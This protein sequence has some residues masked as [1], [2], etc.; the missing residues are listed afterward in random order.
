MGPSPTQGGVVS[1]IQ[2]QV[3]SP[4]QGG[5]PSPTQGGV[6]SPTQRRVPSPEDGV[7][8]HP[9]SL[10]LNTERSDAHPSIET[11]LPTPTIT[12]TTSDPSVP[13]EGSFGGKPQE[14]GGDN[15]NKTHKRVRSMSQ[16][17][18]L[19]QDYVADCTKEAIVTAWL[20]SPL[21][22]DVLSNRSS[23]SHRSTTTTARHY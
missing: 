22:Q 4:I 2:G 1:P 5:M 6:P 16:P 11:I 13:S 17:S 21:V 9:T 3:P 15:V 19:H 23:L 8:I 7:F 20:P 14:G 12:S 10:P 18:M